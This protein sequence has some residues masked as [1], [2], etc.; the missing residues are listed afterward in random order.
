MSIEWV[1]PSKHLILCHPLL[2]PPS[3]FN[4]SL[5]QGLFLESVLHIRWP[6]YWSFNFSISPSNEY[7]GLISFRIDLFDLSVQ[8]TQHHNSIAS[9]LWCSTFLMV[10]LSHPYMTTRETCIA[11][12]I[13]TLVGEVL[14]LLFS[15]MSRFVIAFFQGASVF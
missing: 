13:Q 9:F 4:L 7:S 3:I 5:H 2:L 11:L 10:Q 8:G 6:K 15:T 14:S 1:I 12:T